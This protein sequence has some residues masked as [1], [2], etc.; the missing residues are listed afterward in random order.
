MTTELHAWLGRHPL[1][2]F[3]AKLGLYKLKQLSE[4]KLLGPKGPKETSLALRKKR[5]RPE[6]AR[7][8]P[9]AGYLCA[10][11]LLPYGPAAW[12]LCVLLALRRWGP[13]LDLS[14]KMIN[15]SQS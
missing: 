12:S 2:L 6:M 10:S 13:C 3:F 9:T 7:R 1:C 8:F 5:R 4:A 15:W 11:R 14:S